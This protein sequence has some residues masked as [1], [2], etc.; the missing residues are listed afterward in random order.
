[1]DILMTNKELICK[2]SIPVIAAQSI[3][4]CSSIH[5]ISYHNYSFVSK[6]YF[7]DS[8]VTMKRHPSH[9]ALELAIYGKE[10]AMHS[11]Y[12]AFKKKVEEAL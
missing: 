5:A 9:V 10:R 11:C 8:S 12:F 6:G 1:M 3:F 7:L 2:G 4:I